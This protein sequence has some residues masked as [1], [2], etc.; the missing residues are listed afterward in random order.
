MIPSGEFN[1][2]PP[3]SI[4]TYSLVTVT[5]EIVLYDLHTAE[6]CSKTAIVTRPLASVCSNRRGHF[7]GPV[8]LVAIIG[9]SPF[10]SRLPSL[11]EMP[12][13]RALTAH[14]LYRVLWLARA[15]PSA[16][17]H[18]T[19]SNSLPNSWTTCMIRTK[20]NRLIRLARRYEK[21]LRSRVDYTISAKDTMNDIYY[22]DVG[23]SAATVV[24]S[25]CVS[26]WVSEVKSVLDIPCGHGRV[27]RHLVKLFPDAQFDACDLDADGISF[28]ATRFGARPILSRENIEEVDFGESRYDVIWVGSFFTHLSKNRAFRA[29]THLTTLLT[30]NG[31]LIATFHGRF[32]ALNGR[33]I[34]Y[35]DEALWNQVLDECVA[36]GYGYRDYPPGKGHSYIGG[37]YGVSLSLAETVI[38]AAQVVPGVRIYSYIEQGWCGHQDVL[39]LG[40]PDITQL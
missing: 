8:T 24:Y 1:P 18:L 9:M 30:N 37:S 11:L 5:A 19:D 20:S 26:S 2:S 33:K 4:T 31:I 25:A 21:Y 32:S 16:E 7:L 13:K 23:I 12:A 29:L 10:T 39:V 3:S 34:G 38:R 40:R 15:V 6:N 36:T 27:L 14:A 35:L 28:C 22:K 17:L